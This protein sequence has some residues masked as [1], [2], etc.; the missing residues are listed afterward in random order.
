MRS[1][2]RSNVDMAQWTPELLTR[3]EWRRFEELCAPY[4]EAPGFRTDLAYSSRK[5]T[6]SRP[7]LART[8]S[9]P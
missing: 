8:G 1:G 9:W 4:Y 2:V 6:F 3:L 5:N 7:S